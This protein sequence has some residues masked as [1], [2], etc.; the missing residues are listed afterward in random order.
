VFRR[1][2]S[3]VEVPPAAARELAPAV[4]TLAR[5]E[6]FPLHAESVE[7]RAEE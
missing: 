3:T 4:A 1:R 2:I 6:G 5:A 7:I